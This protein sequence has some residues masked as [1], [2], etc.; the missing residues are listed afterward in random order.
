MSQAVTRMSR[1]ARCVRDSPRR[2]RAWRAARTCTET[3]L[4]PS[5]LRPRRTLT[6][7]VAHPASEPAAG[8]THL[9]ADHT[10]SAINIAEEHYHPTLR[11]EDEPSAPACVPCAESG[12]T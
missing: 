8:L 11:V 6:V 1:R 12:A 7:R 3:C 5:A 9:P 2:E 4:L 10:K